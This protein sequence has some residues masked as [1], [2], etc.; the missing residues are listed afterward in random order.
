MRFRSRLTSFLSRQL[1]S[2]SINASETAITESGNP[3]WQLEEKELEGLG[4]VCACSEYADSES[5]ILEGERL[6]RSEAGSTE[7]MGTAECGT[8]ADMAR[9][10]LGELLALLLSVSCGR[11]RILKPADFGDRGGWCWWGRG[12]AVECI[13]ENGDGN[14]ANKKRKDNTVV[15]HS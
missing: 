12:D 13:T 2:T 6:D 3:W 15:L 4:T 10:S 7:G 5:D 9:S 1:L 8:N 14:T 11:G